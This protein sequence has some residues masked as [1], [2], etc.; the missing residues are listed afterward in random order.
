MLRINKKQEANIMTPF[1]G[2]NRITSPYGYRE[3]WYNGRLI[4]EQ[5]K[6]QDI[7]PT[8]Q[9]GQALPERHGLFGR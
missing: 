3:Y 9:A 7:V 1:A 6:G 2:I 8:Q 5:H 4:K